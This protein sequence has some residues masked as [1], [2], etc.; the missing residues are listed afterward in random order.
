MMNSI[1]NEM[2]V[3]VEKRFISFFDEYLI[4]IG[5]D[6]L[7]RQD[8]KSKIIA[9]IKAPPGNI[10]ISGALV[11]KNI[12]DKQRNYI[13]VPF[14][15]VTSMMD[16]SS[17]KIILSGRVGGIAGSRGVEKILSTIIEKSFS[18]NVL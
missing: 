2:L 4:S 7:H 18:M 12:L 6:V 15:I 14:F 10:V 9:S 5:C 1:I 11:T 16:A 17:C 8:L 3:N 13:E